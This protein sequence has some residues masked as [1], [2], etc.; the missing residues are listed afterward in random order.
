MLKEL[1][2]EEF[3]RRA[4]AGG[5]LAVYREY[6]ADRETPVSVLSRAA[7]DESVFLLESVAGGEQRTGSLTSSPPSRRGSPSVHTRPP[8]N[9]PLSRAAPS[10][11]SPTTSS[12]RS[13]RTSA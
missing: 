12:R 2:F 8:P 10:A 6:L 7:N 5:R 4:S 9:F 11:S 3:S 13:S 1:T